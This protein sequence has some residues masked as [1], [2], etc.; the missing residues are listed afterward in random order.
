MGQ[1]TAQ[2]GASAIASASANLLLSEG[3]VLIRV[4]LQQLPCLVLHPFRIHQHLLIV[5]AYYSPATPAAVTGTTQVRRSRLPSTAEN[6]ARCANERKAATTQR[7]IYAPCVAASAFAY[8]SSFQFQE[9]SR[10]CVP[11]TRAPRAP[12]A[13]A[14]GE[15]TTSCAINRPTLLPNLREP[16]CRHSLRSR[17][18]GSA[19]LRQPLRSDPAPTSLARTAERAERELAVR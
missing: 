6:R 15:T 8:A 13:P 10:S 19:Q 18:G 11:P 1:Q 7:R 17:A 14:Q 5:Q 2:H 4:V 3:A 9:S 16:R 12:C